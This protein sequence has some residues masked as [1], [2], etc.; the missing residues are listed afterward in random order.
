MSEKSVSEMGSLHSTASNQRLSQ[1]R[2][3]AY[4]QNYIWSDCNVLIEWHHLVDGFQQKIMQCELTA[5]KCHIRDIRL[6]K[7]SPQMEHHEL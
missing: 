2:Y 1:V 6:V 7:P 4:S 3:I 5:D